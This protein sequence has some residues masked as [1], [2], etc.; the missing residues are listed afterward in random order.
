MRLGE[1]SL[2]FVAIFSPVHVSDTFP[3]SRGRLWLGVCVCQAGIPSCMCLVSG[4]VCLLESEAFR[5]LFPLPGMLFH[6]SLFGSPFFFF[7]FYLL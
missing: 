1:R 4:C 3:Y 6:T 5:L 7:S 2:E